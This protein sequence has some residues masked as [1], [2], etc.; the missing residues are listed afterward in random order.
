[1]LLSLAL[2]ACFLVCEKKDVSWRS[3]IHIGGVKG[4]TLVGETQLWDPEGKGL[5]SVGPLTKSFSPQTGRLVE[6]E[7]ERRG[8]GLQRWMDLMEI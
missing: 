8:G 7:L 1:M 5:G 6:Y 4:D 2:W 3:D